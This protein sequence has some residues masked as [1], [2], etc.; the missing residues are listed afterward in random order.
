MRE[1]KNS[2]EIDQT[3]GSI[4]ID[5][6]REITRNNVRQENYV[7]FGSD[8]LVAKLGDEAWKFYGRGNIEIFD[9]LD[10]VLDK[11]FNAVTFYHKITNRAA[12]LLQESEFSLDGRRLII[13]PA[14]TISISKKYKTVIGISSFVPG[15][16]LEESDNTRAFLTKTSEFLNDKLRVEG[17]YLLGYNTQVT[18][19]GLV[20]VDIC[21]NLSLL[22]PQGLW[23]I[24]HVFS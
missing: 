24:F 2:P 23:K 19:G 22:E 14:K 5:P 13:N 20:A 3:I 10:L 8:S 9:P 18:E 7:D 6:K 11:L 16:K 21:T 17:I 1:I 4:L 12:K 15:E